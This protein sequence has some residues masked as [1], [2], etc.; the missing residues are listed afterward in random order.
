MGLLRPFRQILKF[1]KPCGKTQHFTFKMFEVLEY[2]LST[3][4]IDIVIYS[5]EVSSVPQQF[6]ALV[7][8][9]LLSVLPQHES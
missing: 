7:L 5:L 8:P 9:G 4:S 2:K 6:L 3:G 1:Y